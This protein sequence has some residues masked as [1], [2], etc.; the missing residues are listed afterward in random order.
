M[1]H[2]F[3]YGLTSK[4][5]IGRLH[6]ALG[7][8]TPFKGRVHNRFVELQHGRT[9]LVTNFVKIVHQHLFLLQ[10]LMRGVKR[11]RHVTYRE[12]YAFLDIDIIMHD[13][14]NVGLASIPSLDTTHFDNTPKIGV[15]TVVGKKCLRNLTEVV[16]I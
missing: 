12:I 9:I 10:M 8:K 5:S 3:K 15:S 14:L 2:D 6:F 13:H 16:Q 7:Y 1:C 11:F 4:Q